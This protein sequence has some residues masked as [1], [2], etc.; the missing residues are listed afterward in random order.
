[1]TNIYNEPISAGRGAV[2]PSTMPASFVDPWCDANLPF[3]ADINKSML[4][5]DDGGCGNIGS[6]NKHL[7]GIF[8]NDDVELPPTVDVANVG[9][10]V[11]IL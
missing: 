7:M 1:M 4:M 9:L 8:E 2:V 10:Q 6:Y 5:M 11:S 3:A